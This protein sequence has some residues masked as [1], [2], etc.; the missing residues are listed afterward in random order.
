MKE[1]QYGLNKGSFDVARKERCDCSVN[2]KK[3]AIF[4]SPTDASESWRVISSKTKKSCFLCVSATYYYSCFIRS[5]VFFSGT[6]KGICLTSFFSPHCTS[7]GNNGKRRQSSHGAQ[8]S[9]HFFLTCGEARQ[10]M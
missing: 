9:P 4:E 8:K 5:H 7:P 2:R 1:D 6:D 3:I 10:V